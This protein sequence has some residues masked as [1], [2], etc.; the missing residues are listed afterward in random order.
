MK[1]KP[2]LLAVDDQPQ[3]LATVQSE[4]QKRYGA[5]YEIIC[6]PSAV[7]ALQRLT[8]LQT[9]GTPVALLLAALT[10]A[11]MTGIDYLVQAHELH[12]QAK[13]ILLIP[14]GNRSASKPLLHAI[15]LGQIDR[16]ATKPDT[17]PDEQF[18]HLITELLQEWQRQQQTPRAVVTIIAE[19]W[20]ARSYEL[21]DLLER[22]GLPFMFYEVDSAEGRL[23]LANARCPAGPF[24]VLIR[25]DGQVFTNPANE[26]MA[27]ALGARH[28]FEQGVFDLA[29]VGAGPAGLSAAVYG[30][31][32]GLR[33][34]VVDRETIGG[35][36]GT[37]SLIRNYLGFPFG[38]SGAE[39]TNR[40]LDQAWA[41]GAETSVLR[42]A[43]D[44]RVA[45]RE[46]ILVF[47]NGTEVRSRAIVL[48][49]GARY[50]RL[51]IPSLEALVGAGVFYGGGVSE[52]QAL[53]G[54]TVFVAGGGNSAGQAAVH[55][56]KYAQQVTMLVRGASLAA[57]MSDYLVQEIES[58]ENIVV[59]LHTKIV[60][61]GGRQRLEELVLADSTSGATQR[62]PAT[63]LFVLIG[64]QP[65]TA[66]LPP[67]IVRDQR[68]FILTGADLSSAG[69]PADS[70]LLQRPPLLLE[71]SVPG[72]FAAGDVRHGSVK[73]VASAVGEGGIA[74]QSV[75]QYLAQVS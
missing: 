44:L 19:R 42:E 15:T 57:S 71:T 46:R 12:P 48:A 24:P 67:T 37:S 59:R 64:A 26:T 11:P 7:T 21:R 60:N 63:A 8:A 41:F 31:S 61:G 73:R 23:L 32:E 30:A 62:V 35:Q 50:Q 36:A 43:V 18:H 40:A 68:G 16:F 33:T 47:A 34:I 17:L 6:E 10:M 53:A 55:L 52:A 14:W 75:H 27:Q 38:I 5:D 49:M 56:A 13:R 1:T 9:A 51:G 25:F 20:A 29:I 58:S 22:S 3:D 45:G 70:A 74:I 54:Q 39:L 69:A 2:I 4:L 72:V 28:S 66:W 65:H